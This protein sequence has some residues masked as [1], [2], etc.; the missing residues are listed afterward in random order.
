[1][2]PRWDVHDIM[3]TQNVFFALCL[4]RLQRARSDF[5]N[6]LSKDFGTEITLT[7]PKRARKMCEQHNRSLVY[8]KK[9]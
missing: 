9:T 1:M 6:R 2:Y 8:T 3:V 4:V 5:E 7:N